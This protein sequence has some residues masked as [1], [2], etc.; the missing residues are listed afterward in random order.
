MSGGHFDYQQYHLDNMADEIDKI[1]EHNDI[2]ELDSWGYQIGENFPSEIIEKFEETSAY[3]RRASDM[4]QRVDWLLSGDDGESSFMS[5][6]EKEVR[7]KV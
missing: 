2:K 6:W 5:R 1:V 7:A 4:V 3:L